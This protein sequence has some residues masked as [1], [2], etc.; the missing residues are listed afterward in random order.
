[1]K[2]T[3]MAGIAVILILIILLSLL[4]KKD[5]LRVLYAVP[6]SLETAYDHSAY[7]NL[8][9]TLEANVNITK[10]TLQGFS[11]K[12]LHMYDV[13]YLDINMKQSDTL[14]SEIP[15]LIEYVSRGGH[16][17]LENG[18]AAD[19][20]SG[21]LGIQRLVDLP[22]TAS[23]QFAYPEVDLNLTGVQKTYRLFA[24]NFL[25]HSNMNQ[26][27]GFHFGKGV[28]PTTADPIVTLNG[29]TLMCRNHVGKGTVLLLSDFLPNRYFI[30]GFDM[31]SGQDPSKGF[32]KLADLYDRSKQKGNP[33]FDFKTGVPLEPYF[34]FSFATANYQLR[35][36]LLAYASKERFGYSVKKVLGPNGRP[37]MA[38]QNHYEALP[39]FQ[40]QAAQHWSEITK[41][42][43]EIPSFSLV[44]ST[45]S[46]GKWYESAT[47]HLNVGTQ[48][49][50]VFVGQFDNSFYTSGV[51]LVSGG[52][53]MK[54][55][56]YPDYRSYEDSI[57][58]PY[59]LYP[60]IADMYGDGRKDLLAGSADG[61]IVLYRN[62]GMKPELYANQP[63]PAKLG[64]P[65]AFDRPIRLKTTTGVDLKAPGGYA[66]IST[67][68]GKGDSL[69]DLLIGDRNGNVYYSLNRGN[70]VF[71]IPQPVMVNGKPINVGS[72]AAPT[73]GD[74]EGNGI[75][76]LVVG[77]G[78]GRILLYRGIKGRT[79]EFD[80]PQLLVTLDSKFAA[81]SLHDLNAD[82][83]L[84]LAVGSSRGDIVVFFHQGNEWVNQGPIEGQTKNQMGT[85]ALVG[86]HNSVPLW[87]DLNHDGKDDLIVGQLEFGMPYAVDDPTSPIAK[88]VKSFV[89]YAKD[90][91]LQLYPHVFVHSYLSD[92]QEQ[93][94]L[95]LQHESFDKLG[96]PWKNLGTNQHT[97][98]VNNPG[99][100]QTM[101]NENSQGLWFNFGFRPSYDPLD[102]RDGISDYMW[103]IPFILEDSGFKNPMLLYTP[104]PNIGFGPGYA[105]EDVF[106]AY[107]KQD[108]PIDYFEH[109]DY[110][111]QENMKRLAEYWDKVR[112]VYDYNF[113]SEQQM[114]AS[115]L[116]TLTAKVQVSQSWL[117]YYWNWIKDKLGRGAHLSLTFKPDYSGVPSQAGEYRRTLGVAVE[118]GVRYASHPFRTNADV[119]LNNRSSSIYFGL[120]NVAKLWTSWNKEQFH[121]LRVNVPY[122]LSQRTTNDSRTLT[123][124]ADG[125]QQVK[126]YSPDPITVEGADLHI[127]SNLKEGTYTITHFGARTTVVI[128]T[129]GFGARNE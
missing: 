67:F 115:F 41:S 69:S 95:R 72:F 83:K 124:D 14:R 36:E 2:Y 63:L 44:R 101:K 33:Y 17:F 87:Y 25:N 37:A 48:E 47:V 61:S 119:Y 21:F 94:E 35:D 28:T 65:D 90:H 129:K 66:A 51:Q 34:N 9:Q 52:Q 4:Q 45:F 58:L 64:I 82:G 120:A 12:Q 24:D 125:M 15:Q 62:L 84:D 108:M 13:V 118:P 68:N 103:G 105:N 6:S 32:A 42:Y 117:S 102:P 27:P 11:A 112:T 111:N 54:G 74:V 98:R 104:V 93:Q 1:M 110:M 30:T 121:L 19:F 18:F 71:E 75:P 114:A 38:F 59:R 49:K 50:P 56:D 106:Q 43:N 109:I 26:L 88:D 123:L 80:S 16:L 8:K 76:D 92:T 55:A 31:K 40:H 57:D 78:D 70:G 91:F 77:T 122:T 126:L 97:W 96:I 73:F 89:Q 60:A 5:E 116:T 86:G 39:A 29:T 81:P 100:I 22:D 85:Y 127:D 20:P 113:V 46:W 3:K 79:L 107:I 10:E 128:K 7:A 53:P 99:R 23:P